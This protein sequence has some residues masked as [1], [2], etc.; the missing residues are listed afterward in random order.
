MIVNTIAV[1]TAEGGI[2]EFDTISKTDEDFLKA[3]AF[4]SGGQFFRAEDFKELGDSFN[5]LISETNRKVTID[6]S[7]Y[8]LLIGLALFTILWI[9]HNFRFKVLPV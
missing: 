6:L 8:F 5:T 3:L 4:N 9:L 1:G 2:T 7:F